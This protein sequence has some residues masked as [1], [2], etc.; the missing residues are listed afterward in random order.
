MATGGRRSLSIAYVAPRYAPF[1]GGV[2][3][4][5]ANLARRVAASGHRVEVLTQ[6]VDRGMP[7]VEVIDGVTVRRFPML[8][9]TPNY[10]FAPGLWRY[11]RAGAARYDI[12]HAHSYH[13]L[14]ALAAA[15]SARGP[16]IFTPHYHGTGHTPLRR[17]LHVPY[18]RVGATIFARAASVICVSEAE[19][20]LVR[21]HFTV[22]DARMRVIPNGI[23]VQPLLDAEPYPTDR[24]PILSVGRLESYKRVDHTIRALAQLDDRF[25]LHIIGVGPERQAL[26]ALAA[27][28]Q[29]DRRVVFHGRLADEEMRRW[30]RTASVY[31]SNSAH[32]AFGITL[33]EALVAGARVVASDI[34]AHREAVGAHGSDLI[35]LQ[36]LG[37][38]PSELA[39]A[40]SAAAHRG[41]TPGLPGIASWDQV[42]ERT[43]AVYANSARGVDVAVAV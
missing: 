25:A 23:D 42:A 41:R 35:A 2:E 7:A 17:A 8:A 31:V 15:L 10:A 16:L 29:I 33:L 37:V 22:P 19:A 30:Y 26:Q 6:E 38:S 4:H 43:L 1:I 21:R 9:A 20:Q 36:P 40:I 27:S 28:L 14:P 12:L 5:V 32:E 18:R 13:A 11:L 34:P 3:T 24:I 39:A